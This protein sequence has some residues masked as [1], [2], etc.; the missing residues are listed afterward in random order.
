MENSE[1]LGT[2]KDV[3]ARITG[4][5]ADEIG[6]NDAFV[7]DL[8][9]DSLS[10]MEVW[11]EIDRAFIDHQVKIPNEELPGIATLGE[12]VD[13]IQQELAKA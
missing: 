11:V 5:E 9:L 3:V 7:D 2:I 1:I 4:L 13:R 6:D 12:A 10:M 8:E